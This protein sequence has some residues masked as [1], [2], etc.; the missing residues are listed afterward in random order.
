MNTKIIK[1]TVLFILFYFSILLKAEVFDSTKFK[2]MINKKGTYMCQGANFQ[3]GEPAKFCPYERNYEVDPSVDIQAGLM[4]LHSFPILYLNHDMSL[5]DVLIDENIINMEIIEKADTKI[6]GEKKYIFTALFNGKKEKIKASAMVVD[7]PTIRY[8]SDAYILQFEDIN[9]DNIIE[10]I[11]PS[12]GIISSDRYYAKVDSI[13]NT[14]VLGEKNIEISVYDKINKRRLVGYSTNVT[15][16]E[17]LKYLKWKKV[18]EIYK[19]DDINLGD[20]IDSNDIPDNYII[21]IDK[22]N[23]ITDTLKLNIT[24]E[25]G[26]NYNINL[27]IIVLEEPKIE[28]KN[29]SLFKD[30][31]DVEKYANEVIKNMSVN[32]NGIYPNRYI[33]KLNEINSVN[34]NGNVIF[35]YEI[36]DT[37]KQRK[38]IKDVTINI[39]NEEITPILNKDNIF[40]LGEKVNVDKIIS[41][42]DKNKYD[43]VIKND[44][45]LNLDEKGYKPVIINVISKQT[46]KIYEYSLSLNYVKNEIDLKTVF[47]E[48]Y[49]VIDVKKILLKLK[50]S[51]KKYKK[52]EI[53]EKSD[54]LIKIKMIY[55]NGSYEFGNINIEKKENKTIEEY[56]QINLSNKYEKIN[57][58]NNISNKILNRISDIEKKEK[59]HN[60]WISQNDSY[61]NDYDKKNIN[62]IFGLKIAYDGIIKKYNLVLGAIAGYNFKKNSLYKINEINLFNYLSY[63]INEKFTFASIIGYS[64]NVGLLKLNSGNYNLSR[65][66]VLLN[67]FFIYNYR[68]KKNLN[69]SFILGNSLLFNLSEKIDNNSDFIKN[70]IDFSNEIYSKFSI[71]KILSKKIKIT[72]GFRLGVYYEN[73][74]V[75]FN[76]INKKYKSFYIILSTNLGFDYKIN[77]NILL[78]LR[79]EIIYKNNKNLN[80]NL[81]LEFSYKLGK[82]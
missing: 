82:R 3:T 59:K 42:I 4:S 16:K 12:S 47:F 36:I 18:I 55:E 81:N 13:V 61:N 73:L 49:E 15:V 29:L 64:Y 32:L 8:R 52:I 11:I 60:F 68:V 37:K 35:K 7:K 78:S 62:K 24:T 43:I 22:S 79:G 10:K 45:M 20:I 23:E 34:T 17:K 31:I 75:Y 56:S 72:S 70:K 30:T 40:I 65:S 74:K 21:E 38:F 9:I 44:S 1:F 80:Y 27:P 25:N 77:D 51:L 5:E 28:Y 50:E 76:S 57:S 33:I 26:S 6:L 53:V 63:K 39:I 2:V 54:N 14:D 41:N 71:S 46:G 67:T 66:D 69:L 19:G 48:D 58:L